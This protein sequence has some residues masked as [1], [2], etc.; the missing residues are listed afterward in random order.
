[1]V[2]IPENI[3]LTLENYIASLKKE[4]PV[5]KA[6]LFGSYSKGTFQKDSDIDVAIFSNYFEGMRHADGI[7]FLLK[8]VENDDMDIEPH[9][10]TVKDYEEQD[11]MVKEIVQDG[12][13]ITS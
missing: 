7:F 2:K 12:I 10:F 11:G 5:E 6:M 3:E 8:H 4:I 13:E 9:P 1:M